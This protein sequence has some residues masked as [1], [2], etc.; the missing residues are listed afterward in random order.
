MIQPEPHKVTVEKTKKR[1]GVDKDGKSIH[2]KLAGAKGGAKSTSRY[3]K[4]LKDEGDV[5]RLKE[6]AERGVKTRRERKDQ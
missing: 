2:H 5:E 1:F 6:I 3:F 4:K